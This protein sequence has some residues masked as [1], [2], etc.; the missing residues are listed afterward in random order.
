MLIADNAGEIHIWKIELDRGEKPFCCVSWRN[1]HGIEKV[2]PL[3][4]VDYFYDEQSGE[5]TLIMGD[6]SGMVKI[7]DLT[8][9]IDHYGLKAKDLVTGN[10]KRNPHR[11]MPVEKYSLDNNEHDGDNNSEDGDEQPKVSKITG[12]KA[13]DGGKVAHEIS[14]LAHK[15]NVK[16]IQ[17]IHSTDKPLVFTAGLDRMAYIWD[18]HSKEC[19]GTLIQGYMMKPSYRWDFPLATYESQRTNRQ[20]QVQATLKQVRQLRDDDKLYKRRRDDVIDKKWR[21]GGEVLGFTAYEILGIPAAG[22]GLAGKQGEWHTTHST[23][24]NWLNRSTGGKDLT[25][26]IY[27]DTG[28]SLQTMKVRRLLE[29]TKQVIE[30]DF[31]K[32]EREREKK[33]LQNLKGR[34][35][36]QMGKSINNLTGFKSSMHKTDKE[37]ADSSQM[38]MSEQNKMKQPIFDIDEEIDIEVLANE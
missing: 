2:S 10:T 5:F 3:T 35:K 26:T 30:R 6:E 33:E 20:T 34:G 36:G 32:E 4:A 1:N 17:Y 25:T 13:L 21:R 11:V 9:I 24:N 19:L 18:R 14:W 29:Q 23:G 31:R 22:S 37:D 12:D 7:E 15:D 8:Y 38:D 27:D 16:A 28:R